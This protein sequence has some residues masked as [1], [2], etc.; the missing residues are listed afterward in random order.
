MTEP[1]SA[2]SGGLPESEAAERYLVRLKERVRNALVLAEEAKGLMETGDA[3]NAAT[4]LEE[5]MLLLD[6]PST[7]PFREEL[8]RMLD[9]TGSAAEEE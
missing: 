4:R 1:T 8:D 3:A 7:A 6:T 9:Q 5:A 2:R